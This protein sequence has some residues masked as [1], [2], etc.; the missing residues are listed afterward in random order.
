LLIEQSVPGE[1]N[2]HEEHRA[3]G[4]NDTPQAATAITAIASTG[5]ASPLLLKNPHKYIL[6]KPTFSQLYTHIGTAFQA[7]G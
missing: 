3:G 1:R 5:T 2:G 7:S 6:F 4:L